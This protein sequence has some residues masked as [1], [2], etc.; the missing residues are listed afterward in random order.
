MRPHLSGTYINDRDITGWNDI[1]Y[2]CLC[3]INS[4]CKQTGRGKGA[5]RQMTYYFSIKYHNMKFT[6]CSVNKIKIQTD[7]FAR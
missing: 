5:C 7:A 1:T 3:V 6:D 4:Q 2:L